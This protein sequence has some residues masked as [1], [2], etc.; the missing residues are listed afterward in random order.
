MNLIRNIRR[1]VK[2]GFEWAEISLLALVA[3]AVLVMVLGIF[4]PLAPLVIVLFVLFGTAIAVNNGYGVVSVGGIILYILSFPATALWGVP[5]GFAIWS[6]GVLA[7]FLSLY[8]CILTAEPVR[9]VA[10]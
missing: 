2:T 9:C 1:A 10:K 6:F 3:F 7:W 8:K 5:L 4:A